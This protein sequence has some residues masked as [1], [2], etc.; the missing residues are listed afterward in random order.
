MSNLLNSILTNNSTDN[1]HNSYVYKHTF[2]FDSEGR[3]KPKED[4][5]KLLPS[6]IFGSPVEYAKDLKK[7]VVNIGRAMKGQANDHELGRINDVAMKL[8]SF[9]LACYLFVKNPLKLN[10]TMEFVGLSTFFTSMALWPKLA[11]QAPIK[12]RTGVDIHQKYIDSQGRK[13]MMFQ[14]PQYDLT[15]LYSRE[16]LDRIGK[17]LKVSEN[18]PDRDRFIKQRAKKL[19]TQ[20]NTLWMMSAGLSA[21]IMSALTCNVLEK[22]ITNLLE[23]HALNSTKKAMEALNTNAAGKKV[24][25][26][27]QKFVSENGQTVLDDASLQELMKKLPNVNSSNFNNSIRQY[28]QTLAGN[29]RN[30]LDKNIVEQAVSGKLDKSVIEQVLG[31]MSDD[32]LKQTSVEDIARKLANASGL[33]HGKKNKLIGELTKLIKETQSKQPVTIGQIGEQIQKLGNSLVNFSSGKNVIEK[34]IHAR[35]GEESGTYI[36]NQWGRVTKSLF[37]SLH[38]KDSELKALQNGGN[39]EII[40]KKIAELPAEQYEKL[41]SKLLKLIE[42]YETKTGADEMMNAVSSKAKEV[43]GAAGKTLTENG[44]D[45]LARKVTADIKAGTIENEINQR[46]KNGISGAKSSFY[47]LI[48]WIDLLKKE[49][50]GDLTNQVKEALKLAGKDSSDDAVKAMIEKCKSV[51]L[52][53]TPSDYAEKLKSANFRLDND[54]YKIVTDILFKN[55]EKEA[56]SGLAA[57]KKEIM[58]KLINWKNDITP[59]LSRAISENSSVASNATERSALSGKPI[60]DWI[61]ESAKD[62][63]TSRKWLKIFGGAMIAITVITLTVG[64]ILGRKSKI[65][66][67]VEA[68]SKANG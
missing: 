24:W 44:F 68:E 63:Y 41:M 36:A 45:D 38:L 53:A 49:Q 18:L 15:D 47:R 11:I 64:L 52:G 32:L 3:V 55:G 27:V 29:I 26:A 66:K 58:D 39:Y 21:P 9:A 50:S 34:F 10:K 35:V 8:G 19:A 33:S 43:C 48:Q 14:D 37:K 20:G 61:K 7:D 23:K 28:I 6:R 25:E 42:E 22:P 54:E 51:L 17:K 5:A 1:K 62:L 40:T 30:T 59:D 67:Q 13:K 46:A 60:T 2:T 57:Y 12:A 16:D 31:D 4:K 65:E 56:T